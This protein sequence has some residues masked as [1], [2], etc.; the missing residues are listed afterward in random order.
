MREDKAVA[1]QSGLQSSQRV[2]YSRGLGR[3]GQEYQCQI[4]L[5]S[6][7]PYACEELAMTLDMGG[8]EGVLYSHI[9][10]KRILTCKHT[11]AEVTSMVL[12]LHVHTL[13]VSLEVCL[14]YE[15]LGAVWHCAW[16]WVLPV[17]GVRF[18]M[19][20]EVVASAEEFTTSLDFALKIGVL[21]SSEFSRFLLRSL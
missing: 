6:H 2:C 14:S 10:T 3:V 20:L 5:N 15:F 12:F 11:A 1:A 17:V 16:E 7:R 21:F 13:I 9:P 19:G 4:V 8:D 18:H